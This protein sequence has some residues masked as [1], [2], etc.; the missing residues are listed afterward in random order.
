MKIKFIESEWEVFFSEV[1]NVF[2]E[3]I[4]EKDS[5]VLGIVSLIIIDYND[6]IVKF[7]IILNL[8]FI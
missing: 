6:R 2:V 7:G 5:L 4:D 8:F 1:F 3:F